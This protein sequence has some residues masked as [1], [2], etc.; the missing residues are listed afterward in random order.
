MTTLTSKNVKFVYSSFTERFYAENSGI[1]I[2]SDFTFTD[3]QGYDK[4]D[5][6][7]TVL[8]KQ[9]CIVEYKIRTVKSDSYSTVMIEKQKFDSLMELHRSTGALPLYQCFYNDGRTLV[10]DLLRC[11]DLEVEKMICPR[12]SMNCSAG[13]IIKEVYN[14]ACIVFIVAVYL[15]Q[16][17]S[18]PIKNCGRRRQKCR[19]IADILSNMSTKI[20]NYHLQ[21]S[22]N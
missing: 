2:F 10:F 6:I 4:Y 14:T 12:Y 3:I 1:N 16:Y 21:V 22:I 13:T 17:S 18:K 20:G 11:Q 5:A 19:H 9:K 7:C 15:G 8:N